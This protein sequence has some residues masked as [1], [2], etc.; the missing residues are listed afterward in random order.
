MKKCIPLLLCLLL[1]A[2]CARTYDGPTEGKSVLMEY[3][4]THYY[5]FSGF[6]D[7]Q[8]VN[9]ST[10]SYDIYGNQVQY[11]RYVDGELTDETR[12]RYDEHGNAV[13]QYNYDHAHLIPL[14]T[15]VQK[16]TYDDQG[17]ILENI[18]CNGWGIETS[19]Y[20]YTYDDENR[21]HAWTCSDGS[22]N[23]DYLDEEGRTVR[24]VSSSGYETHYSYS[25]DNRRR[26]GTSY[27]NGERHSGYES[28][29]DEQDRLIR[30]TYYG[31]NGEVKNHTEYVYDDE[32]NTMTIR[33]S[34]GGWRVEYYNAEGRTER[35]EDFNS[36]GTLSLLQTYTY[37]DIQVPAKEE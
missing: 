6:E 23:T 1:L 36:D 37:R 31:K 19:R 14:R 17:R 9:R 2:G 29:Y 13:R 24:S 16:M 26:S 22:W 34:D 32:A 3:T 4:T 27:Y 11:L 18:F 30:Y 21:I 35:I 25:D 28:V 8:Y 10:F 7:E 15:S 20:T 33:Q 5:A 12:T